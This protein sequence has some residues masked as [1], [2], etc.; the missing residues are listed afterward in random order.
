M[1]VPTTLEDCQLLLDD[2]TRM[3]ANYPDHGEA[4]AD[5]YYLTN[6]DLQ[7]FGSGSESFENYLWGAEGQHENQWFASYKVIL[8]SNMVLQILTK[9][10]S[11][12]VNYNSMKGSALFFR[13]FAFYSLAQ[14]FAAPY[15]D[16]D[17]TRNMGIP[18]KLEPEIDEKQNRGTL[19]QTYERIIQD[20]FDALDLLP[21]STSIPTRPNKAAAYAMLARIYLSMEDYQKAGEMADRCLRLHNTLID[22]NS[23]SS[24]PTSTTVSS[25]SNG[26]SFK[27]FNAEV[28]FHAATLD[29]VLSQA[30]AR[31]DPELYS[32]Y[33]EDDRRKVVYF[34]EGV[35]PWTWLPN[36]IIGFRGNYD[37]TT[38][39][40]QFIGLATDE[41]YLIRAECYARDGRFE[42]AMADL[43]TLLSKRMV[44]PYINRTAN[45]AEDALTKILVERRKELIFRG[46]R[47]T[48]LRRLNRDSRFSVILKR[49]NNPSIDYVPLLPGDLRYI[50]LIPRKE[51]EMTGIVQNP[52]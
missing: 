31:I 28:I 1:T 29:G 4:A 34:G 49:D 19:K 26:P 24:P 21:E 42:L 47:W 39:S 48:D 35:D 44:P 25:S 10:S 38:N 23:V 2:Y 18:L 36:G 40:R 12:D 43:N 17:P 20:M 5:N 14:I 52:R 37:G 16:G 8:N 51:V 30:Q 41:I 27:R 22:Y 33:T 6:A 32:S 3:N 13:A 7:S 45:S 46:Q 11:S 50:M 9:K 15:T